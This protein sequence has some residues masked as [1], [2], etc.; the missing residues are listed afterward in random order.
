MGTEHDILAAARDLYLTHGLT[1]FSMRKVADAVGIS[2][3]A[4]Y[5]HF[6]GR[7]A[8]ILAVVDEGFRRFGTYLYRGLRGR[9]LSCRGGEGHSR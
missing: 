3:T 1:G 5:R 6:D 8:L 2:A 9:T 7:E 4:I